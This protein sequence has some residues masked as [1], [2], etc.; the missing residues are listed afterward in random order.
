MRKLGDVLLDLEVILDEMVDSHDLQFGDILNLVHGHLVIH[1]PDAREEYTA[2]G[3]PVFKYGPAPN[4]KR[5]KRQ[6]MKLLKILE[7]CALRPKEADEILDLIEKEY[8]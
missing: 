1:R 2:G 6:L 4:R 7:S 3:N 8:L 5:A